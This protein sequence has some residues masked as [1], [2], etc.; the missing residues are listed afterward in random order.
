VSESGADGKLERQAPVERW[1]ERIK[2]L[3]LS[4]LAQPLLE[5]AHAFGSLPAHVLLLL[6]PLTSGSLSETLEQMASL[7]SNPDLLRQMSDRLT[8]RDGGE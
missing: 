6:E 1:A 5:I 8:A 7:L 3:G 4:P 2:S